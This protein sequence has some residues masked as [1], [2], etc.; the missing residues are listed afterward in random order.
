MDYEQCFERLARHVSQL[1]NATFDVTATRKQIDEIA[2][3]LEKTAALLEEQTLA[4]H[5]IET[6]H[7]ERH[8]L[9]GEAAWDA[10]RH[11]TQAI[12]DLAVSARIASK[13]IPDP[14]RKFALP[15]AAQALLFLRYDFNFERPSRSN[16]DPLVAE[17]DR[18]CALAGTP[19]YSAA[20]LRGAIA[21]ALAN[22]DPQSR[23][24][25]IFEVL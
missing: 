20:R 13:K 5:Y 10:Y 21:E 16:T 2:A 8:Q 6:E 18:L 12:L 4:Q 19:R 3:Q 23:P 15:M 1:H 9:E 24:D 25:N 7:G 11:T 14:R 17:L 22:F